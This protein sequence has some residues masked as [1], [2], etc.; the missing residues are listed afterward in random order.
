[1]SSSEKPARPDPA[2]RP[3]VAAAPGDPAPRAP[4]LRPPE[5]ESLAGFIGTWR[6]EGRGSYPTVADFDY[7]E[8]VTLR[9]LGRPFLIYEQRTWSLDDGRPLHAEAGYWRPK[10]DGRIEILVAQATGLVEVDEGT[11][12]DGRIRVA[13]RAVVSATTGPD[14]TSVER[15]LRVTGDELRYELRMAA[16]GQPLL[17]HLA[18][19]LRRVA[20]EP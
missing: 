4:G 19:A 9:A 13:S 20:G 16:V 8:E 3:A 10:P 12:E 15:D 17:L 11:L 5:L 1:M 14:V 6:G 7:R 18:A 2:A